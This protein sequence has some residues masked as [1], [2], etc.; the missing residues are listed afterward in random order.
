M[1][2]VHWRIWK[3]RNGQIFQQEFNTMGRVV[4]LIIE[5]LYS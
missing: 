3:E 2:L 5:D 1:L 4:E